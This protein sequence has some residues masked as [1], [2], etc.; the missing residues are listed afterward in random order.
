MG[1]CRATAVTARADKVVMVHDIQV[2]ASKLC[3]MYLM[4]E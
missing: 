3:R 4:N 2:R 1:V